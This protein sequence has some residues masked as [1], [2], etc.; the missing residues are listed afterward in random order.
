MSLYSTLSVHHMCPV[1]HLAHLVQADTPLAD[2]PA[3]ADH[4]AA[5]PLTAGSVVQ[6]TLEHPPPS[7]FLP[8]MNKAQQI[9]STIGRF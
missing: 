1:A 7:N 8:E 2:D 5:S 9:N 4:G 3:W 6:W